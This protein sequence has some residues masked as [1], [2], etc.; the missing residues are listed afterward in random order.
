MRSGSAIIF[1]LSM[2][3]VSLAQDNMFIG[4]DS[5][6]LQSKREIIHFYYFKV[7]WPVNKLNA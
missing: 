7:T 3:G 6:K 1:V 5:I 4:K 2:V